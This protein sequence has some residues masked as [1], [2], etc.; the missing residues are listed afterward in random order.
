MFHSFEFQM[1]R[2]QKS[3]PIM[4][5]DACDIKL[6][7]NLLEDFW[8]RNIDLVCALGPQDK[9]LLIVSFIHVFVSFG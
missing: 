3:G 7:M 9:Y 2:R 8:L 1:R 6:D 4:D 5:M